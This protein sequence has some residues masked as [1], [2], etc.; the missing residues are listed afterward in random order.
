L[1]AALPK[2]FPIRSNGCLFTLLQSSRHWVTFG[3]FVFV[4]LSFCPGIA[5]DDMAYEKIALPASGVCDVHNS[6]EFCICIIPSNSPTKLSFETA[7]ALQRWKTQEWRRKTQQRLRDCRKG[8]H[9]IPLI[10]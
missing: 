1:L 4:F 5:D 6:E 8:P 7:A 9:G 3:C 10:S 2:H